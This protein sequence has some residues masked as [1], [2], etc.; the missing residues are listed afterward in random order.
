MLSETRGLMALCSVHHRKEVNKRIYDIFPSVF[1]PSIFPSTEFYANSL[2]ISHGERFLEIGTGSGVI[3]IEA[4]FKGAESAVATDVDSNAVNNA[5]KNIYSHDLSRK[6]TALQSDVF[7][8][9]PISKFDVIFWSLPFGYVNSPISRKSDNVVFDYKYEKIN[10]YFSQARR[11]LSK[12]G[13]LYFGFSKEIG[14]ENELEVI[15]KKNNWTK[16]L[17]AESIEKEARPV[18]FGLYLAVSK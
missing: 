7:S 6:I 18:D 16:K 9:V 8:N 13:K 14:S 1:S 3:A 10:E 11:Y 5:L 12:S 2:P 4:L 15:L 17:I